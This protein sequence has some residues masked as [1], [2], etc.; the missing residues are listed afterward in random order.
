MGL[1]AQ[2]HL[3]SKF[4]IQKDQVPHYVSHV[5]EFMYTDDV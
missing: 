3:A 4:S 1:H 5:G 2:K